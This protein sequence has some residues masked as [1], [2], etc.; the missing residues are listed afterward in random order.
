MGLS[1]ND[2][3][4]LL[5]ALGGS[6]KLDVALVTD[7]PAAQNP[8]R[9]YYA[10]GTMGAPLP[11]SP[12][13]DL[14]QAL[15]ERG[16]PSYGIFV[17]SRLIFHTGNASMMDSEMASMNNLKLKS[18]KRKSP[19]PRNMVD[20]LP[21][22][23]EGIEV[24]EV[25]AD[26]WEMYSPLGEFPTVPLGPAPNVFAGIS[27]Q[28]T[29]SQ[30][31]D[32]LYILALYSMLLGRLGRSRTIGSLSVRRDTEGGNVAA[33]LVS[34]QGELLAWGLNTKST[35][36]TNH[37]EVNCLQSYSWWKSAP[38]PNGARLFTT[39]K[40]CRM[41]AGM[42]KYFGGSGIT[43]IYGQDD[44]G[45]DAKKTVLK[46]GED[47]WILGGTGLSDPIRVDW[48]TETQVP[49]SSVL[50]KIRSN[51]PSTPI[52]DT[53]G[54]SSSVD[55]MALAVHL[56]LDQLERHTP[57]GVSQMESIDLQ[58]YRVIEHLRPWLSKFGGTLDHLIDLL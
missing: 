49:L 58:A 42:I 39:L 41:C 18:L 6:Q 40:P 10:V 32:R 9:I 31:V 14:I 37:A 48:G 36:S 7:D 15:N 55:A 19:N 35:N 20:G 21:E 28:E 8:K 30:V 11:R 13:V 16:R 26:R 34:R 1:Q 3:Q 47:A 57:R 43:V 12:V 44:T 38:V 25:P 33:L 56:L 46:E 17:E 45:P 2:Y 54:S 27:S 52:V 23:F 24:I 51:T 4:E 5:S 50:G 22:K 29:A 53:L